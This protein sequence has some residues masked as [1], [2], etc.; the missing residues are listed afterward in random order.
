MA[1]PAIELREVTHRYARTPVLHGINLTIA[2]GEV[3]GF[4]GHNGAGKT[5]AINVL[6]TLIVPTSGTAAVCG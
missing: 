3:F 6:T 4:L 1:D 5:T 2:H